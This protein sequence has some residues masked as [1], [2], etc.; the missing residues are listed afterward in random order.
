MKNNCNNVTLSGFQQSDEVKLKIK[1]TMQSL[2][3]RSP[4]GSI[5]KL[6][7]NT[8]ECEVSGYLRIISSSHTFET[9]IHGKNANSVMELLRI[10]MMK[11][12]AAW[13]SSRKFD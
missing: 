2:E 9:H 13:A 3:D 4:A 10:K 7:L 5:L 11:E 1:K 6:C 12:L 8:G